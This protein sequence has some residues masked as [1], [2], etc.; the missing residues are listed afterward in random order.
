M[1]QPI[2]AKNHVA[3]S[4]ELYILYHHLLTHSHSLLSGL[5][6][7]LDASDVEAID[8]LTSYMSGPVS[9]TATSPSHPGEV[10]K[11]LDNGTVAT[12]AQDEV[13]RIISDWANKVCD[14]ID[15]LFEH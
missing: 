9:Q 14:S 13:L 15:S 4:T 2:N 7:V 1:T 5:R 6:A 10:A 3:V 12:I 11:M 8:V